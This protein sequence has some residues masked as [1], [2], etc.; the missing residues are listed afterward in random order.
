VRD[1]SMAP[2]AMVAETVPR[3]RYAVFT[4]ERGPVGKVVSEAWQ[5]IWSLEEAG[6]LGGRRTYRADFEVYGQRSR[7]PNN[8]RVEIYVGIE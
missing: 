6:G 1:G 8:A 5:K 2:E 7:D 4:T 3:G